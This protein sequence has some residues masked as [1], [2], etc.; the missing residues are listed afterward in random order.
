M[1]IR[2]LITF[3]S[4]LIIL[5]LFIWIAI[6]GINWLCQYKW[7]KPTTRKVYLLGYIGING[8]VIAS[9]LRFIPNGFRYSAFI[10]ALLFFISLTTIAVR[11]I[12]LL[13]KP[14]MNTQKLSTLLRIISPLTVLTIIALALYN[15]YTPR[16]IYHQVSLDKAITPLRIGVAS[17]LHLG[18]LFGNRQLDKLADLF[19]QE[20]VDLI[21]LPGDIMDDNTQAYI[22]QGMQA[23]LSK[24]NAPLGV[25][26]TLGNHDFF[27]HQLAIAQAIREA[28]ITLLFDQALL[29]EGRALLIGRNDDLLQGRPSTAQILSQLPTHLYQSA[30]ES[31]P[32]LLLDHR[33]T[34]IALNAQSPIEVQLSGHTH[35]G[36]IF[37]ANLITKL[38]Y[39]LDYG[40][41]KFNQMHAFVTSGYGFWGIPLRL[42]SQSEILIIDIKGTANDNVQ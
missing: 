1:S 26:A 8:F 20:H 22:E 36:Q 31:L 9:L 35:K 16:V 32:I 27:G 30:V 2:Y 21:L 5:Q 40:Y 11:I 37:P 17:D 28:G 6:N 14:I 19:R 18:Q 10:L 33:P 41:Q 24:L 38:M 7:S 25:Y 12:S 23:H 4:V 39:I 15:A 34:E 42:G 13:L 29:I 3:A